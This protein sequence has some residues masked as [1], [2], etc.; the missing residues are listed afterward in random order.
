MKRYHPII[1][2]F[3]IGLSLFL[4][5]HSYKLGLGRLRD[6]GPGLMP[7]II[8]VLMFVPSAYLLIAELLKS[9]VKGKTVGRAG[10]N[11]SQEDMPCDNTAHHLWI[12]S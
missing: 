12:T 3:W 11:K 7:F 4:M 2:V 6:P 8:G 10:K 9:D 1:I 5:V